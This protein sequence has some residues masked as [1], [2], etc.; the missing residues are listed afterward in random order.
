[1][2][3]TQDNEEPDARGRPSGDVRHRE[4]YGVRRIEQDWDFKE[5]LEVV[6]GLHVLELV[7]HLQ[8][9]A[10]SLGVQTLLLHFLDAN[11]HEA[12]PDEKREQDHRKAVAD[13]C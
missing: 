1:M 7:C 4:C 9:D 3:D 5:I 13:K 8:G 6:S 12:K 2:G 10:G 11:G